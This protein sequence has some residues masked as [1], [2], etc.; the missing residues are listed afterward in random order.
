MNVKPVNRNANHG[1]VFSDLVEGARYAFSFKPIR[2][3]L[4]LV[5]TTGFFGLPFQVFM[6]VFAKDILGGGSQL[7]GFLTG[8]L[9]A[10]ALTGAIYLASRKNVSTLPKLI[11]G[12]AIVF[13]LGLMSMSL[14][15]NIALSLVLL[16]IT[17]FGM[18]VQYASTNTLIQTIVDDGKRG[19]VMSLYG[20][21]FLGVTPLGSLLLGT[22][23]GS[24]GVQVT[25]LASS[26]VCL[27]AVAIYSR[28]VKVV[29]EAIG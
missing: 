7:L 3:L 17:G 24:I 16:Y 23:S 14:S 25:L 2:F 18:I 13:A 15:T 8:A 10:G 22:I 21:S 5:V 26:V 20:M 11:L 9:G 29:R 19:R 1:S 12:S 6:P 27:A 4:M 28:R